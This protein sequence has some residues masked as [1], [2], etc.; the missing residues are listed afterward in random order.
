[1]PR[2]TCFSKMFY[3]YY[4]ICPRSNTVWYTESLLVSSTLQTRQLIARAQEHP[5]EVGVRMKAQF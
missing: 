5:V 4:V 2:A 1:M 3:N